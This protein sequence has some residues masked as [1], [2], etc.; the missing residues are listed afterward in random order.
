M[1]TRNLMIQQKLNTNSRKLYGAIRNCT[2]GLKNVYQK[3]QNDIY[4]ET[5]HKHQ[6]IFMELSET[7]N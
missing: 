2:L 3:L 1:Y 4:T 6:K 5:E 7:V